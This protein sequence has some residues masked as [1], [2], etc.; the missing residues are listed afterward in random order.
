MLCWFSSLWCS[1]DFVKLVILRVFGII[2][3]T[4]GSKCWGG[5]GGIFLT[6]CVELCLVSI[7]IFQVNNT[8]NT[9]LHTVVAQ[10]FSR[11]L[12]LDVCFMMT[13]QVTGHCVCIISELGNNTDGEVTA[14][15]KHVF[16]ERKYS[17]WHIDDCTRWPT[18]CRR[19]FLILLFLIS[20]K[21]VPY[22]I[23]WQYVGI[24]S[25]NG[26]VPNRRQAITLTNK[27]QVPWLVCVYVQSRPQ[28]TTLEETILQ[29]SVSK[30]AHELVKLGALNI[31][32]SQ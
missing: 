29:G 3:R 7:K 18:V 25:G 26:L 32:T 17:C 19:H 2:W 6:L 15:N 12:S 9:F 20:L 22:G 24:G 14:T 21:Y 11:S 4:P 23:Y 8:E 13:V 1:F 10:L 27:D 30:K 28:W 5:S 16:R 31:P